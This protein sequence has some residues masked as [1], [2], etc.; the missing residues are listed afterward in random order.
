MPLIH[1]TAR[2]FMPYPDAPVP[3]AGTGPLAG[4]TF[5][6]KDLFHVAG[7]PTSGGQPLLLAQSGIKARTAPTVSTPAQA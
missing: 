6:V 2:C 4:L 3:H 5:A 1:D 7:Y